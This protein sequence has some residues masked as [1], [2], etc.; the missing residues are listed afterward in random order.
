MYL[1]K[2][3]LSGPDYLLD[4]VKPTMIH[5]SLSNSWPT[6]NHR[7]LPGRD[8]WPLQRAQVKEKTPSSARK[9]AGVS[10]WAGRL[11]G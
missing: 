2:R 4:M 5:G 9:Q 7:S 3:S 1:W 6:I 11:K 8:G 10:D